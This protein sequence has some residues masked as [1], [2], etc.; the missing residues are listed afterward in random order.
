MLRGRLPV[1]QGSSLH[2]GRE[3]P[4]DTWLISWGDS[5]VSPGLSCEHLERGHLQ[6]CK[7]YL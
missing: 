2:W 1:C 5:R 3:Q 6:L 7:G 4:L